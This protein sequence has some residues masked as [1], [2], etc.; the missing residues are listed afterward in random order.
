[1][2]YQQQI[3]LAI[4]LVQAEDGKK[5]KKKQQR[6]VH[7]VKIGIQLLIYQK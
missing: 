2:L 1:M 7:L 6:D 3:I 5:K 4:Q